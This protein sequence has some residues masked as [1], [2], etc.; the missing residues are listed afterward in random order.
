MR[1]LVGLVV[2]IGVLLGALAFLGDRFAKAYAEDSIGQAITHRSKNVGYATAS[3]DSFPFVWKLA[4][5]GRVDHVTIKLER[6]R[7][8]PGDID[9]LD[10]TA[11]GVVMDKGALFGR[12]HVEIK[13]VDQ[14]TVA[15]LLSV[16]H[17]RDVAGKLGLD[18]A[19]GNGVLTVNGQPVAVTIDGTDLVIAVARLPAV[20][21]PIPAGDV[22]VLPCA[23]TPAITPD[24]VALSCR[25]DHL[26]KILV[27]AIGS[28]DLKRQLGG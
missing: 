15:A 6:L 20:R 26:P 16:T 11:D 28:L 10:V 14:V 18:L 21:V 12:S 25:A 17:V 24:G 19:F 8:V 1:K 4:K 5:D 7:D 27:D 22:A 13:R 2:I 3:I 9:E 23:P